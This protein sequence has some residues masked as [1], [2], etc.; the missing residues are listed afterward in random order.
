MVDLP[1]DY[2]LISFSVYLAHLNGYIN[3]PTF[4]SRPTIANPVERRVQEPYLLEWGDSH[5]VSNLCCYAVKIRGKHN[6]E[7]S[8]MMA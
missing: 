2:E 8:E 4:G 5:E 1:K 6:S 3:L 7:Q